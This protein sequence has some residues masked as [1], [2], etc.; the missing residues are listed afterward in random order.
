MSAQNP[1]FDV[2][3]Q[4]SIF[5]KASL[6][7]LLCLALLAPLNTAHARPLDAPRSAGLVG[8][9]YDG[10]CV[11]RGN[12]PADIVALVN[13]TNAERKALYMERAK[14]EGVAV[15]AIGKIYAAEIVKSAPANTWFLSESGAWKQK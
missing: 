8:E 11:V 7:L 4:R 13:Q 3:H 14:N 12:A 2:M 5:A 6:F 15:E 1:S 10:Y 9:R